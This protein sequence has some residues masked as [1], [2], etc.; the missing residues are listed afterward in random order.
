MSM[1]SSTNAAS[2][3]DPL[4]ISGYLSLVNVKNYVINCSYF[5]QGFYR[6]LA[7]ITKNNTNANT[8]QM[9]LFTIVMKKVHTLMIN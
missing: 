5:N 1:V 8:P 4:L 6:I 7:L 3:V 9:Y 2:T